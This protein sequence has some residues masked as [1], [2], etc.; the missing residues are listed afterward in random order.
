MLSLAAKHE[1]GLH[2][3]NLKVHTRS[4]EKKQITRQL[5]P[6]CRFF[7]KPAEM[8]RLHV[9]MR[10]S[11]ELNGGREQMDFHLPGLYLHNCILLPVSF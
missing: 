7:E 4:G 1:I 10:K 6:V 8:A 3:L 9:Y 5:Y 2:T 11:K